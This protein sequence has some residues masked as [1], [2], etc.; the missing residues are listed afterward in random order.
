M[1]ALTAELDGLASVRSKLAGNDGS[2][3]PVELADGQMVESVLLPRDGLCVS[4]QVGCCVCMTGKIRQV[5]G[6]EILAQVVLARRLRAMKKVVFTGMGEPAHN[7][8]NM[9]EAIDLL[10]A[11][12][13]IGQKN[14][15]FPTVGDPRVFEA[16]PQQRAKPALALRTTKAKLREHQN[17]VGRTDRT[18]RETHSRHQLSDPASMEAAQGHQR[19][20]R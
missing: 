16:L 9:L 17:C 19:Q 11:E 20:R 12:G 7:L 5:T 2:R 3:L 8:D 6:M 13:N 10:G 1:P 14:L 18:W 15:V 4:T